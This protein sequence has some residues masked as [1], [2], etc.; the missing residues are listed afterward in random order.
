L[1]GYLFRLLKFWFG[2]G[3]LVDAVVQ[4]AIEEWTIIITFDGFFTVTLVPAPA[5]VTNQDE[6]STIATPSF[7]VVTWSMTVVIIVMRLMTHQ[8]LA[9]CFTKMYRIRPSWIKDLLWNKQEGQ[10]VKEYHK[11]SRGQCNE[12]DYYKR[13]GRLRRSRGNCTYKVLAHEVLMLE[14]TL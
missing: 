14:W 6:H 8:T 9:D 10:A 2:S 7:F 4:I 11:K 1:P 12:A 13:K 5:V 3:T